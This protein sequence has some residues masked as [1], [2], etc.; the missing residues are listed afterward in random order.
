MRLVSGAA[1]HTPGR[2]Q[3]KNDPS[4]PSGLRAEPLGTRSKFRSEEKHTSAPEEEGEMSGIFPENDQ[5]PA[6]GGLRRMLRLAWPERVPLAVGAGALLVSSAVHAYLP[7][8]LGCVRG[9]PP[10]A[11][12]HYS[13]ESGVCPPVHPLT[14]RP[15]T[16]LALFCTL[17]DDGRPAW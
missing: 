3:Q 16:A 15:D 11:Y 14:L 13:D 10:L 17:Q 5:A 8:Y 7:R 1:S 2:E 9:Q 4:V 6:K 12:S